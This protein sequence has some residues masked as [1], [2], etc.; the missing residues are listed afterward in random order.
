MLAHL[1]FSFGGAVEEAFYL[2]TD[3][4]ETHL[5]GSH[6][7]CESHNDSN[8]SKSAIKL[9]PVEEHCIDITLVPKAE[10][11]DGSLTESISLF[12]PRLVV[13][14]NLLVQPIRGN[15]KISQNFLERGERVAQIATVVI[16]C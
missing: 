15:Q 4:D 16:L 2:C 5:E 11:I 9:H 12:I 6:S 13:Q 3:I 14:W 10:Q 8:E 1:L 7:T